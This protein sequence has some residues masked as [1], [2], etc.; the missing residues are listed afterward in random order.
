MNRAARVLVLCAAAWLAPAGAAEADIR[1]YQLDGE[2]NERPMWVL[3][4]GE[5]GCHDLLLER[6]VHRVAQEG[7]AW[8]SVYR[9]ENCRPGSEIR[10]RWNGEGDPV[11]SFR[12][13]AQ[14]VLDEGNVSVASWR[15]EDTEDEARDPL[16]DDDYDGGTGQGKVTLCHKGKK[17]ITVAEPAVDAHLGH[18]DEIGE[19]RD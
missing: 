15:C 9:R 5:P 7:F 2:G 8:C 11:W 13:G 19:C 12:P 4:R 10:G 3:G 16:A 18:G 17:T 1:F 14:W 6:A